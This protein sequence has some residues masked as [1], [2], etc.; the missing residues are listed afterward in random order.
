MLVFGTF[1]LSAK[2]TFYLCWFL[3]RYCEILAITKQLHHLGFIKTRVSNKVRYTSFFERSNYIWKLRY[4][5][6][7]SWFANLLY[8]FLRQNDI[9]NDSFTMTCFSWP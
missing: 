7:A 9:I 8:F 6:V 4:S 2:F 3:V 5:Y 1:E